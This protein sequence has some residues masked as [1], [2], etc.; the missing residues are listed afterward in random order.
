MLNLIRVL[1]QT[2][3]ACLLLAIPGLAAAQPPFEVLDFGNNE[4]VG[5]LELSAS[6]LSVDETTVEVQVSVKLPAGCYIYSMDPSFGQPTIIKLKSVPGLEP[7]GEWTAN[8][9]PKVVDDEFLGRVEKFFD[10]VTW[11]RRFKSTT[12]NIPADLKI[13]GN[14]TGQYC[15][16]GESGTCVPI[17]PPKEFTA[18]LTGSAVSDQTPDNGQ[19]ESAGEGDSVPPARDSGSES[20]GSSSSANS[21]GSSQSVARI[22]PKAGDRDAPIEYTVSIGSSSPGSSGEVTLSIKAMVKQPWHTFALDQDPEMS[23]LPTVIEITNMSGLKEIDP[24]FTASVEPKIEKPLDDIVQRVHFGEVEWTRRF[25]AIEPK[26][27]V[28][29]TISYQ[30][31]KDGS[32]LNPATVNFAVGS[33]LSPEKLDPSVAR[34]GDADSN[35][36]DDSTKTDGTASAPDLSDGAPGSDGLLA[37]VI[38][39]FGAGFVALLTPCV[40]PMV[41]VTVAFFLKQ[42]EKKTGSPIGLAIVYCLGIVG[43]F[44]VLGLLVAVVFGPTK[45][46]ALANDPWLNLGFSVLFLVFALMLLGMF[47]IRVP[48][49]LL[50]WS[51]RRES[52]GGVVGALF[53]ALTFTL[54]SFTC[55]FAFVGTLLVLAAKGDRFWPILGMLAFSTAFA[56]PFFLLALFPSML[57]KL[58]KSG[59]WMN[60]VKVTMG[61]VELALV[62]KFLSVADIGFS[63]DG[64]PWIV[65][66]VSFLSGWVVI[67]SITGIYLLGLFRMSHDSPTDGISA[68]RCFMAIGFL[69]FA[70]YV[71]AGVF[72]ATPPKG[73]LWQQVAAF[74]PPDAPSHLVDFREAV[75]IASKEKKPLFIDFT[76]VNCVNCRKM[77]Q[78]V[79]SKE[80]IHQ[81]LKQ[82]VQVQLYIDRVPGVTDSKEHD[83]LLAMNRQL[84]TEWFKDVT[85]PGY[86]IVSPDGKVLMARFRGL[87]PSGGANFLKFLNSG[88][89]NWKKMQE[90]RTAKRP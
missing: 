43:T 78:T 36:S 31:C 35:P 57:K 45:L 27:S 4:S 85:L 13:D 37:F 34:S 19:T 89:A 28:E 14:L 66:R 83:A 6:I 20:S 62:L 75:R 88:L 39:A 58:P 2:A 5:E 81:V 52:S 70:A 23:G 86:A 63:P 44:T 56:S 9:K 8:K 11:S 90:P 59:G 18:R 55:T 30:L 64:L 33:G 65:D 3:L 87:D 60:T 32:C 84:Q 80:E 51:S 17:V 26:F 1:R 42:S 49:W 82:T 12:G 72:A 69:G 46:N 74:A 10:D 67:A 22:I 40:F 15:S 48:S 73:W 68:L 71:A 38:S 21:A 7:A 50:T 61:L 29:G 77:E 41:P 24:A 25:Q 16:S 54:V 79:L 47:E 53:M 76:G